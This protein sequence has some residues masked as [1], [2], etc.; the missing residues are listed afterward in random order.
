MKNCKKCGSQI[1]GVCING[2]LK[3][4]KNRTSC[5][6]CVP[7][8]TSLYTTPS[9]KEK[10]LEGN[11]VKNKKFYD[12][13]RKLNNIGPGNHR[14][15]QRRYKII[16]MIGGKCQICEYKRTFSA[17][18]FHHLNGEDKEQSLS[19]REFQKSPK[20]VLAEICKCILVCHNCHTE[21]HEGMI[22]PNQSYNNYICH[23][24]LP[25]MECTWVEILTV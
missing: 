22:I 5:Y 21:I 12:K 7:F 6:D 8:G 4:F 17:L 23:L 24:L 19:I 9:S 18:A 20:F 25:Y 16:N 3:R 10:R 14:Y 2:K 11:R 1:K 13:Y 15:K